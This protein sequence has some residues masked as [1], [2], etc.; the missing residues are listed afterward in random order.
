MKR[1]K[2]LERIMICYAFIGLAALF[3]SASTY[4]LNPSEQYAERKNLLDQVSALTGI[5][6]HY[7]AAID[8]YERTLTIANKQK[9]PQG[10]GLSSIYISPADWS[11]PLNPNQN[12]TNPTS[13]QI[14]GGFGKDGDGDGKADRENDFDVLGSIAHFLLEKGTSWQDFRIA[15][16]EYYHNP[17]SVQR[18]SQFAK[19]Y[20]TF[21][22]LHLDR[23]V[24]PLPPRT[25]YSYRSTW[26]AG[27]SWGGYRIHEGT[28]IFAGYGVPVRSTSYGVIEIKGWNRYGGWRVGIRDIQNVY[29]YYAHLSGF[30]KGLTVGQVVKP[31]DVIGWVGSSGYGKPG[32]QGKFPP[33]L[34]YGL[35]R[36]SGLSEWPFDPT[37]YL[38]KWERDE[39]MAKR[40]KR[41]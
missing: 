26:G 17:R 23:R 3:T 38:H 31:G 36:D 15:L 34:H 1:A 2:M 33:H 39:R 35:Y 40:Q 9:R 41:Y 21:G 25:N 29:H 16:W 13:I 19:I 27:R 6:W 18:I 28:D 32:T 30:A 10:K 22:T 7:L 24:F 4:A 37:P 20:A 14:F 12:D 11:G 5:P 8:Q